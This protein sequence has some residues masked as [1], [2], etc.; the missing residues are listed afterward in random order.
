MSNVSAGQPAIK[1]QMYLPTYFFS[2][3]VGA[4]SMIVITNLH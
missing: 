1:L 2:A 4:I 3:D